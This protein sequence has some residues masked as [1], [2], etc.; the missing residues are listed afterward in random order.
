MRIGKE[1]FLFLLNSSR[2]L[3]RDDKEREEMME[4]LFFWIWLRQEM[5]VSP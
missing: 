2:R 1:S 3:G 4:T 5:E